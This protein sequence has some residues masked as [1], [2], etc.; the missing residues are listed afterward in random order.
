[1]MA[2]NDRKDESG[3]CVYFIVRSINTGTRSVKFLKG[4]KLSR[5]KRIISVLN[6]KTKVGSIFG[7]ELRLILSY[8]YN[9]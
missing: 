6:A 5:D 1:M 8:R 2:S 9:D 4:R 3:I 7:I